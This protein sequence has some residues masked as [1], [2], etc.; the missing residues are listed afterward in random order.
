LQAVW[1][2]EKE[3]DL[4]ALARAQ[5]NLGALFI[6]PETYGEAQDLLLRAQE[7]QSRLG[8]KVALKITQHNLRELRSL[9]ASLS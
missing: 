6:A 9:I 4:F 7:I 1:L 8:D 5:S 3:Q 2:L